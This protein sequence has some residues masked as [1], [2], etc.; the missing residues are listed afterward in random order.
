[1]AIR[2]AFGHGFSTTIPAG[3]DREIIAADVL[4]AD[5]LVKYDRANSRM[6]KAGQAALT[7]IHVFGTSLESS[8]ASDTKTAVKCQPSYGTIF[9][10]EISE[11]DNATALTLT[12]GSTTTAVDSSLTLGADDVLIGSVWE[13]VTNAAGLAVGTQVTCTDYTNST[14]TITFSTQSAAMASGDTIKMVKAG[15]GFYDYPFLEC[16]GDGAYILMDGHSGVGDWCRCIGISS[17][18][19]EL[20][21]IITSGNEAAVTLPSN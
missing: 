16:D 7:A 4:A 13:V 1:M 8:A 18:G 5:I 21:I 12:G 3:V 11:I 15:Q 2:P 6:V 17:D 9:A 10:A 19:T 14:G 20:Y